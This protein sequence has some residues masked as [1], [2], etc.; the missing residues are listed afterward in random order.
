MQAH[1]DPEMKYS[2]MLMFDELSDQNDLKY[3]YFFLL[4]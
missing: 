2:L 3:P 1:Y 4:K